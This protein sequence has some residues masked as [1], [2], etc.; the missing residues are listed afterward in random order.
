MDA[1]A[2]DRPGSGIETGLSR[3][4]FDERRQPTETLLVA[5]RLVG[6]RRAADGR[7]KGSIGGHEGDIRL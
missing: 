6:R 4:R 1:E 3:R 7:E 5:D 2:G